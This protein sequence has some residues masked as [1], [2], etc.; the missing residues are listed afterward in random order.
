MDSWSHAHILSMLEGGNAQL[1]KFFDR[2]V[3]QICDSTYL[4]KAARFYREELALHV[5]RVTIN[6]EYG[7]RD[8][9]RRLSSS[10]KRTRDRKQ[11]LGNEK[12]LEC[13]TFSTTSSSGTDENAI[14]VNTM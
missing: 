3:L 13:E 4:T 7:G 10:P 6:G 2:H 14:A 9:S 5:D 1:R 8:A 12:G 11:R